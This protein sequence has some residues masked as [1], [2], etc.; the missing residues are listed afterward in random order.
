[1]ATP[2]KQVIIPPVRKLIRDGHRFEKS[3]AGETTFAPMLTTALASFSKRLA[4][5]VLLHRDLLYPARSLR[6]RLLWSGILLLDRLYDS[7]RTLH[8][9]RPD[10]CIVP[11]SAGASGFLLMAFSNATRHTFLQPCTSFGVA[12]EGTN[13]MR[14][15]CGVAGEGD[16]ARDGASVLSPAR[17]RRIALTLWKKEERFDV[18]QPKRTAA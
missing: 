16:E 17:S 7:Q 6:H 2:M 15:L 3:L 14:L 18:E 1:M 8:L 5:R 9:S 10:H 11:Q 13:V 12:S 4:K